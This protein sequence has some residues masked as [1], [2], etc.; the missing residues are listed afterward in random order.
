MET[1]RFVAALGALLTLSCGGSPTSPGQGGSVSLSGQVTSALTSTAVSGATL[2][3]TDGVNVGKSAT[4]DSSGNF[5][6]TNLE[7]GNFTVA[8]AAQGFAPQSQ[9]MS[10]PSTQPVSFRLVGTRSLIYNRSLVLNAFSG[11]GSSFTIARLGRLEIETSWS[12]ASNLVRLELALE[13]SC[14]APQYLSNS[15]PWLYADR[16]AVSVASRT[17]TIDSLA[18]NLYIVWL[19]NQGSTSQPTTLNV[20]LTP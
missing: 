4:T 8:V 16:S 1:R 19:T 15:C 11:T 18:P 20:Y 7:R 10:L 5:T 3:I 13:A 9:A 14:G 17:A 12:N 2:T 6:F